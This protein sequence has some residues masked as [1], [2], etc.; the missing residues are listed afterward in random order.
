MKAF[1]L[2]KRGRV[3]TVYGQSGEPVF[4]CKA[5]ADQWGQLIGFGL[6]RQSLSTSREVNLFFRLVQIGREPLCILTAIRYCP[7]CGESIQ[8]CLAK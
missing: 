7:F 4:C 3:G 2:R 5:M 6:V 8:S 1:Y